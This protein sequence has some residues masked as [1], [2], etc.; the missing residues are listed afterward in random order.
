MAVPQSSNFSRPP[1]GLGRRWR[2]GRREVHSSIILVQ[3]SL[4]LQQQQTS[5]TTAR[6]AA[7][8]YSFWVDT[9]TSDGRH[10]LRSVWELFLHSDTLK[11]NIDL[12]LKTV[13]VM[14]EVFSWNDLV[15][16]EDIEKMKVK[17]CYCD[18]SR[19]KAL[20]E[21][22]QLIVVLRPE[23]V[24]RMAKCHAKWNWWKIIV[25]NEKWWLSQ[26]VWILKAEIDNEIRSERKISD[27]LGL[28]ERSL[29]EIYINQCVIWSLIW[30]LINLIDMNRSRAASNSS[31]EQQ[32]NS[33]VP[34]NSRKNRSYVTA[35]KRSSR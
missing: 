21:R 7:R 8:N 2:R 26:I 35:S 14:P 29:P 31:S 11:V 24:K 20:L 9:Y 28:F 34:S 32:G 13:T 10:T 23:S 15:M 6:L 33:S 16:W 1:H 12:F 22:L 30:S 5:R 27:C 18:S 17:L 25:N 4:D 19:G 3:N